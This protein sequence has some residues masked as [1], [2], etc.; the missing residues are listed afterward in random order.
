M[1]IPSVILVCMMAAGCVSTRPAPEMPTHYLDA[2]FDEELARAALKPGT[3]AV[4]GSAFLRQQ[5]GG[6]VTCAG[7]PVYLTPSTEYARERF[8]LLYGNGN[9]SPT[10]RRINFVPD[11]PGY[12]QLVHQTKCDAQGNFGIENVA[13]GDYFLST[14]VVWQ[15]GQS[16]QGGYLMERVSVSGGIS[17]TLILS[18]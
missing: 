12:S 5:G 10:T 15:V 18:R 3:N 9:F 7:S 17:K 1:R 4:R 2:R 11:T 14:A 6:V 13:D 16:P 8:S